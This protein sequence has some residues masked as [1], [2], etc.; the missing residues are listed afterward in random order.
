M[1]GLQ[2]GC[3]DI[4]IV[5][6]CLGVMVIFIQYTGASQVAQDVHLS[7]ENNEPFALPYENIEL[8]DDQVVQDIQLVLENKE[9]FTLANENI[10]FLDEHNVQSNEGV[11]QN[12]LIDDKVHTVVADQFMNNTALG[13]IP[14]DDIQ[15]VDNTN[16]QDDNSTMQQ[17]ANDEVSSVNK[18]TREHTLRVIKKTKK[19]RS[20][21]VFLISR[22]QVLRSSKFWCLPHIIPPLITGDRHKI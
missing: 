15:T 22:A 6:D 11:E 10:D 2:S 1:L 17:L 14:S 18:H 13:L 20:N 7:L 5:M 21:L 19:T 9:P 12:S 4:E 3:A 8:F 16:H